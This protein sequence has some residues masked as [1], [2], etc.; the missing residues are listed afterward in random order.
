MSEK[1]TRTRVSVT[2]TEAYLEALDLLVDRGIYL[3][4]GEA[5]MEGIRMLFRSYKI[6]PFFAESVDQAESASAAPEEQ[7]PPSSV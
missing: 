6:E 7:E 5:I 2:M 4:R 3:S 1:S